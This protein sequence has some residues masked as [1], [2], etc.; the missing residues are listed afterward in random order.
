MFNYWLYSGD[1]AWVQRV[2]SNYTLGI[3]YLANKIDATTGLLDSTGQEADW[4]RNGGG[5]FSISPNV[6]YYKVCC[7]SLDHLHTSHELPPGPLEQHHVGK[8]TQ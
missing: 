7:F 3:Q 8:C 6:L 2:W 5:N 1:V 4:G